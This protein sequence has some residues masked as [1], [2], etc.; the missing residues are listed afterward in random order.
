MFKL[1]VALAVVFAV[2]AQIPGGFTDRPELVRDPSTNALV[3]LAVTELATS[4][5]LRAVPLNV[6]SVA[7][8]VVNGINYRIVFNVRSVSN[9]AIQ[10]CTT[11]I[12]QSFSGA[13]S[14]SSVSCA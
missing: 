3:K 1:L 13:Q 8:Q 6:V 11:K 7:T 12:Y 9:N 14:V 4:Q 5:N 2:Q 10:T